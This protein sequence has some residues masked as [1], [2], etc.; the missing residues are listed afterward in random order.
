[1]L[2]FWGVSFEDLVLKRPPGWSSWEMSGVAQSATFFTATWCSSFDANGTGETVHLVWDA[3]QF[4]LG[5]AAFEMRIDWCNPTSMATKKTVACVGFKLNHY[6]RNANFNGTSV[7]F[8]VAS[9]LGSKPNSSAQKMSTS[10]LIAKQ[11]TGG[12]HC[13]PMP[14]SMGKISGNSSIPAAI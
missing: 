9:W 10:H 3:T 11:N 13:W 4:I 6:S 14:M 12:F 8:K 7:G 2:D 5:L 1:M